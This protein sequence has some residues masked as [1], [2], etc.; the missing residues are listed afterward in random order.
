M[1]LLLW[2]S[3]GHFGIVDAVS[4]EEMFPHSAIMDLFLVC[5]S[6]LP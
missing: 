4:I 2:H 6:F 5:F 1:P 3:I